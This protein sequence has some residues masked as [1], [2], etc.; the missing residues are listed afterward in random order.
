MKSI[1]WLLLLFLLGLT[2]VMAS[3]A[4]SVVRL[5]YPVWIERGA[6]TVPL[7]PGDRLQAGD[8]VQTGSVG[9]VWLRVE[10]GSVIKLGQNARFNT[11]RPE[12]REA[13]NGTVLEAAFDVLKGAFRYTSGFFRPERQAGARFDFQVGAITV[14]IRGTDVWGRA[15][16]DEDFVALLDGRIEVASADQAAVVMDQSLTLYRKVSGEP[17]DPVAAVEVAIVEGLAAETELDTSA[18]I[19][20]ASGVYSLVLHSYTN[21][22]HAEPVLKRLRDV[23]YAV[24]ARVVEVDGKSYT[25]IQLEGLIH[26][27]SAYNLR[28]AMIA[29]GLIDDAWINAFE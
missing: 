25:R 26:L 9:R 18:G 3:A 1:P 17:A 10:D 24:Q 12:F 11:G 20:S 13:D 6:D 27:E 4:V 19:A 14:G 21:P 28:S 7:A 23:G 15:A 29:A 16:Q 8:V 2:P 22:D 5:N